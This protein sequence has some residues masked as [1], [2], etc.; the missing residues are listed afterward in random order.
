MMN[1]QLFLTTTTKSARNE[2][3]REGTLV[4]VPASDRNDQMQRWVVEKYERKSS[5]DRA[6]IPKQRRHI[7]SVVQIYTDQPFPSADSKHI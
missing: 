6:A 5:P 3:R 7:D 2:E 4:I 1:H